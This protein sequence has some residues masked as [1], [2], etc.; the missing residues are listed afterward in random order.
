MEF[1]AAVLSYC[2]QINASVTSGYRTPFY[3]HRIGAEQDSAHTFGLGADV[4]YDRPLPFEVC[5]NLAEFLELRLRREA[6]H[7]HLQP[8]N[9]RVPAVRR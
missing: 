5:H 2:T 4:V 6:D 3:N 7:D 1:T 8:L 9:W